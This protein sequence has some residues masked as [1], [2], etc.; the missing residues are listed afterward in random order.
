L[1]G[2]QICSNHDSTWIP[3]AHC[4]TLALLGC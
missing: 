1:D 4:P 3:I 2:A